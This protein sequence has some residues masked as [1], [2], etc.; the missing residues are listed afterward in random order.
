[1]AF[2]VVD[3][4]LHDGRDDDAAC[5]WCGAYA[6]AEVG[7]RGQVQTSRGTRGDAGRALVEV[8]LIR[9]CTPMGPGSAGQHQ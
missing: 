8:A 3:R 5:A 2:S 9:Y 7:A 1:M 6:G 4:H